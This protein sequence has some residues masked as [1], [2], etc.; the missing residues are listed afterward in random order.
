MTELEVFAELKKEVL[1]T[2]QKHYPFFSGTWK[3]FSSKDILQLIDLIEKEQR[4]TVSEKWVYT[5]LKPD[6]NERLPRKDMLDIFSK[7]SG[8]S[9][10]DEFHSKIKNSN[11]ESSKAKTQK[12][13]YKNWIFIIPAF[14]I[15]GLGSF[16]WLRKSAKK[17]ISIINAYSGKEIPNDEIKI[18]DVTDSIKKNLTVEEKSTVK[19]EKDSLKIV[20]ESPFYQ[21]KIVNIS[22]DKSKTE[23]QLQPNDNAMMIKAFLSADI[24]DWETRKKQLNNMLSENIEVILMLRDNL[25][26]EYFDKGDFIKQILIPTNRLKKWKI[27]EIKNEEEKVNFIRIQE[28]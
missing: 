5:H 12:T 10:W 24:K 21:S 9:G 22:A 19:T 17:E 4:N 28:E 25:G 13:Y 26:S 6:S 16:F 14:F 11:F 18:Y 27:V 2:Y 20:I 1:L 7:F 3:N 23:I 8:Y 15:L